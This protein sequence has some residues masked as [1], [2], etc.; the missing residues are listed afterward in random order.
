LFLVDEDGDF[1]Y[2][3]ADGGAFD[4]EDDVALV[5]AFALAT[6]RDTIRTEFDDFVR[7][8]EDDLVRLG[9]LGDRVENGGLVNGAQVQRLL[10]GAVWQQHQRIA[11]IE[12]RLLPP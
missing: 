12:R 11:E 5:R 4:S 7:Y 10:V 8:N 6:S 1:H 2:D 3:G 9:V